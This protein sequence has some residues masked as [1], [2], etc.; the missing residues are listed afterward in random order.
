MPDESLKARIRA[1]LEKGRSP[2]DVEE[3]FLAEGYHITDIHAALFSLHVP[4]A[5]E[6]S[7]LDTLKVESQKMSRVFAI[8]V[9]LILIGIAYWLLT[10]PA[11]HSPA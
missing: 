5:H 11:I 8:V 10:Q 7:P 2:N 3:L 6:D 9:L 1:E 4:P